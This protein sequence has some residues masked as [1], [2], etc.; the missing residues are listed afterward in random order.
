M[1]GT[2]PLTKDVT[3][4]RLHPMVQRSIARAALLRERR[5]E[6]QLVEDGSVV[7]HFVSGTR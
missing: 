6:I 5:L 7:A 2:G 4:E 3:V 1:Q